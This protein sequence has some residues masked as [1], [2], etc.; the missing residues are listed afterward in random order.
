MKGRERERDVSESWS[1]RESECY[2]KNE[3]KERERELC[4]LISR[5]VFQPARLSGR[6][7]DRAEEEGKRTRE[8]ER[9]WECERDG[10]RGVSFSSVWPLSHSNSGLA[11]WTPVPLSS[12]TAQNLTPSVPDYSTIQQHRAR[13]Q[14]RTPVRMK[15]QKKYHLSDF[16]SWTGFHF[17]G[18]L[19][20]LINITEFNLDCVETKFCVQWIHTLHAIIQSRIE[21]CHV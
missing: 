7:N 5:L 21:C 9:K 19:E 10:E 16:T 17:F 8:R 11:T 6:E 20:Y 12:P 15:M 3:E 1:E 4:T 14:K 2:L 13:I 18:A